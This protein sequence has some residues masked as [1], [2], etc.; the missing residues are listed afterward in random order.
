MIRVYTSS[1]IDASADTVWSRIRDF[2]ACRRGTRHRRQPDRERR[3]DHR[4]G[5]IRHFHTRDGGMI[6]ERLVALRDYDYSCSYE[7][8][9]SPMG[10]DNYVA[11]L[12]LTPVTHGARSFVEWS[13]EFDCGEG[14]EHELTEPIGDG[15][16]QGGLDAAEALIL[17]AAQGALPAA[18]RPLHRDRR[19]DRSRLGGAARLQQPRPL[20]RRRRRESHRG[21]RAQRPGRLRAQ[22]H[23]ERRKPHPRATD[24]A[25]R[26]RAQEHLLHR[27]GDACRCSATS[28]RDAEAGDRRRPHVLALGVDLRDA[29]GRERELR[30]MVARDVYEAGFANLRRHLREGGDR[31]GP[32]PRRCRARCRCRR[33]APSC[34]ATAGPRSCSPRRRGPAPGPARCGSASA[35]SASTTSTSTC[36]R[37]GSRRCCR[38]RGVPGME[39]VGTVLDVGEGVSGLLPGDRVAYLGR[40]PAPFAACGRCRPGGSCDSL[41]ASKTTSRPRRC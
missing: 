21:R 39:A 12:K 35:R 24:R 41:Q 26:Q 9:E 23:A 15:V 34:A 38:C 4:L 3:G 10:V 1:V 14:R 11:T 33:E 19:A 16:F 22:L 30:E 40:L 32:V 27:R 8:L 28:R 17:S 13:A 2:N 36:A 31:R 20:A 37:A 6:R 25:L 5:C 7:I 18:R 29:A